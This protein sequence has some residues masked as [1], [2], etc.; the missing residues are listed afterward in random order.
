[1]R[2]ATRHLWTRFTYTR[3]FLEVDA[4]LLIFTDFVH[5]RGELFSEIL[6]VSFTSG[7]VPELDVVSPKQDYV[8]VACEDSIHQFLVF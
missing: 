8:A 4:F 7:V 3:S 1:M 6:P 5:K 2:A